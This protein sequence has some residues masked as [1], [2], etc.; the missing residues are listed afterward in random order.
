MK[1]V[2][3]GTDVEID[4]RRLTLSNLDKVLYPDA[5]FTKAQVIDYY[6]RIAPAL[7][8]H[9]AGRLLTLKRYPNG[10]DEPFFYEKQCPS[11]RPPWMRTQPI[12][13][14]RGAGGVTEYCVVDDVAGLA[15]VANMASLELHPSLALAADWLRPTVMVFDLDPGPPAGILEC[16]VVAR[17]LREAFTSLNLESFPKTSGSKGVQIYVPLNGT[18]GYEGT[19]AFSKAVAELLERLHRELVVS[20][21]RKDLRPGKVL[22]DW[23]QNDEHKTTVCVYSL[24]ARPQPTVSTP[25]TWPEMEAAAAGR[26]PLVFIA[27]DVLDR[28]AKDGDHFAGVARLEQVLPETN[29]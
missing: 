5:G 12:P 8:P 13:S 7:L 22:I 28:V 14:S 19:K 2:A 26:N 15:W 20:T 9:L 10:V 1:S 21:Q 18:A 3:T 16:A 27:S 23:S 29:P 24:R 25:V 17:L 4:G 11:H 6:V